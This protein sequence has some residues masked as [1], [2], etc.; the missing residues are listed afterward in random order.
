MSLCYIPWVCPMAYNG[1][2]LWG[3]DALVQPPPRAPS[4]RPRLHGTPAG[5]STS[6][7][8]VADRELILTETQEESLMPG[9]HTTTTSPSLP[10][11]T[12]SGP[13]RPK[14]KEQSVGMAPRLDVHPSPRSANS[15]A[16]PSVH[17]E[18][19]QHL[20]ETVTECL[21]PLLLAT[22]PPQRV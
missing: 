5:D 21:S 1:L 7:E 11:A 3:E 16:A 9:G 22:N 17:G 14:Y 10:S 4:P 6:S 15:P 12:F 13:H 18:D 20:E 8:G 19:L 2:H